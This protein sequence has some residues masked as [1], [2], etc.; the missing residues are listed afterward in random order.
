MNRRVR[1]E[2]N[3]GRSARHLH[4]RL[5]RVV[6]PALAMCVMCA[7]NSRAVPWW[8]SSKAP[9]YRW[10][11]AKGFIGVGD[12]SRVAILP[13]LVNIRPG[14]KGEGAG[15]ALEDFRIAEQ[16]LIDTCGWARPIPFQVPGQGKPPRVYF[17]VAEDECDDPI[18]PIWPWP[19]WSRPPGPLP[20][21]TEVVTALDGSK[22]W[23]HAIGEAMAESDV[24]YSVLLTVRFSR[25]RP[26]GGIQKK[27]VLL[28]TG[29]T[30]ALEN[31]KGFFGTDSVDVL[32]LCGALMD[33]SGTIVRAAAEG[34]CCSTEDDARQFGDWTRDRPPWFR[35]LQNRRMLTARRADLPGQPLAYVVATRNLLSQLLGRPELLTP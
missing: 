31:P 25:F 14:H 23:R 17:G 11:L 10:T 12:S 32:M 8:Q 28:G 3:A 30:I 9:P 27:Q 4:L 29:H 19:T 18:W 22:E 7:G 26:R 21:K 6:V 24:E 20:F 5:M 16:Q 33:S 13:V 34:V 2:A 1:T 15:V 35:L